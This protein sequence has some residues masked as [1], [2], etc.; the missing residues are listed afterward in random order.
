MIVPAVWVP[1]VVCSAVGWA[2][3]DAYSGFLPALPVGSSP[4]PT[5]GPRDRACSIECLA[6]KKILVIGLA[7]VATLGFSS[8]TLKLYP[9]WL[10]VNNLSK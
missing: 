4:V 9:W 6:F 3:G 8:E 10:L 1:T 5:Q 7:Y 2:C